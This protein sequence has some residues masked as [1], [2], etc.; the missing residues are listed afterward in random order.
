MLKRHGLRGAWFPIVV[1][2]C[3]VMMGVALLVLTLVVRNLTATVNDRNGTVA[4][5]TVQVQLL[6]DQ[7][8]GDQALFAAKDARVRQLT[9]ALIK[10]GVPVPAP[11]VTVIVPPIR[12]QQTPSPTPAPAPSPTRPSPEP[13]STPSP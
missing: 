6:Q 3:F 4:D 8:N 9:D 11:A 2:V 10:A 1:L 5:L 13:T 7:V 12:P